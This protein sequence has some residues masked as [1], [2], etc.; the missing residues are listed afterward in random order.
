MRFLKR[1]RENYKNGGIQK[2]SV[3]PVKRQKR[4]K[5]KI[6]MK[7]QKNIKNNLQIKILKVKVFSKFLH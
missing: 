7:S 1:R 5:Q 3:S 4:R 6:E 2:Q